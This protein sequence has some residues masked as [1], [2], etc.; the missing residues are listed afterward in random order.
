[1]YIKK[2]ISQSKEYFNVVKRIYT[3]FTISLFVI[4]KERFS[5]SN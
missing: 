3:I 2:K 4:L 1:M 5:S